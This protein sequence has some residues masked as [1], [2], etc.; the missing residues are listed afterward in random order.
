MIV[1]LILQATAGLLYQVFG[2][3]NFFTVVVTICTSPK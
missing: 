2:N 3:L 1:Q